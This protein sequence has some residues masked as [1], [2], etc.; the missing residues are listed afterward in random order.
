MNVEHAR[1]IIE[2]IL[3]AKVAREEHISPEEAMRV[4]KDARVEGEKDD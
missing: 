1:L 4:V 2:L 3:A